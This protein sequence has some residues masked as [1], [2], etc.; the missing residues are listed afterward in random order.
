MATGTGKFSSK[1]FSAFFF[2]V[3]I[4]SVLLVITLFTQTFNWPMALFMSIGIFSISVMCIYYV[5]NQSTLDMFIE[6]IKG[7][8]SGVIKNTKDE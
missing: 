2:S 7:T 4:L 5:T 3:I 8:V 1:K 6:S